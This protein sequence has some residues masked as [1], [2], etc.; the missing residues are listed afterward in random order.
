MACANLFNA[1]NDFNIYSRKLQITSNEEA[2]SISTGSLVINGGI[3][4]SHL[5]S[6][7]FHRFSPTTIEMLRS[8]IIRST[9]ESTN[10]ASGSLIIGGGFGLSGDIHCGGFTK[11]YNS[12]NS[13]DTQTGSLIC[14]GGIG[15]AKDLYVGGEIYYK[16]T[17]PLYNDIVNMSTSLGCSGYIDGHIIT[18]TSGTSFSISSGTCR[19][20]TSSLGTTSS[21]VLT[22]GPWSDIIDNFPLSPNTSIL[23]GSDGIIYQ[24]IRQICG[25]FLTVG[26]I[27]YVFLGSIFKY[28]GIIQYSLNNVYQQSKYSDA[29]LLD[30]LTN[31]VPLRVSGLSPVI[32]DQCFGVSGGEIFIPGTQT[33]TGSTKNV[34]PIEASTVLSTVTLG[35]TNAD[36]SEIFFQPPTS[37][38]DRT[39][40]NDVATGSLVPAT[41]GDIGVWILSIDSETIQEGEEPFVG[42]LFPQQMLSDTTNN[43]Q[44]LIIN[45]WSGCVKPVILK[46]FLMIGFIVAKADTSPM[47]A[48]N[49][50]IHRVPGFPFGLM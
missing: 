25:D 6:S 2:T 11:I 16:K 40:Y 44:N 34:I 5:Y 17:L 7:D 41:P 22:Y 26:T 12:T 38:I 32:F 33:K 1:E 18:V 46:R 27:S 29:L 24:D 39:V 8:L 45:Y 28:G 21:N 43:R 42:C 48:L 47:T 20:I 15:L 13:L 36:A 50:T 23:L 49:T 9:I 30:H 4:C 10:W 35:Y 19:F 37:N 31:L 14:A 3:A